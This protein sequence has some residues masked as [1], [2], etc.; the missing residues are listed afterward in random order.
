MN[1]TILRVII[2]VRTYYYIYETTN[3]INGKTYIG[4]H[5]TENLDD[6]YMGSDLNVLRAFK[7]YGKENF[8]KEIL[9]FAVN[10]VA[11]NFIEKCLV[12]VDFIN[13]NQNYNLKEGGGAKGRC[14]EEL[15]HKLSQTVTGRKMPEGFGERVR[16]RMLGKKMS[17]ENREK[18]ILRN[19]G[20]KWSEESRNKLSKTRKEMGF[21]DKM[22]QALELAKQANIDKPKTQDHK[23]ALSKSLKGK[24]RTE[25]TKQKISALKEKPFPD[26]Y[27]INTGEVCRNNINARKFCL[28]HSLDY[29][30]FLYVLKVNKISCKG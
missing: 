3:L 27:N 19:T 22:K 30:I 8:R 18:L 28:L 16:E 1:L 25:E 5:I 23:D 26:V 14:S 7:K 15:K 6:G 4:Q 12:T 20:K 2:L 21:T 11:L 17:A 24:K 13:D 29:G 9:L 10:E